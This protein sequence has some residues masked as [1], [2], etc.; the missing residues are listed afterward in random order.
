MPLNAVDYWARDQWQLE[1]K[2]IYMS[3]NSSGIKEGSTGRDDSQIR[4][5]DFRSFSPDVDFSDSDSDFQWESSA[6]DTDDEGYMHIVTHTEIQE[7]VK[8]DVRVEGD[9]L[10][11]NRRQ[12][13]RTLVFRCLS[14]I[15]E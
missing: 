8:E 7:I 15:P 1:D 4:T 12:K 10:P 2:S 9:C 11:P 13:V 6:S 5:I 14:V 3:P